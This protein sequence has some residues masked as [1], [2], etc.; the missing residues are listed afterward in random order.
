LIFEGGLPGSR[1]FF[2][3]H[4]E[5]VAL[6]AKPNERNLAR[7]EQRSACE[8]WRATGTAAVPGAGRD[9]PQRRGA[10]DWQRNERA[11]A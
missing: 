9:R 11:I 6:M 3:Q 5:R 10:A 4:A 2:Q 1:N 8:V 7:R